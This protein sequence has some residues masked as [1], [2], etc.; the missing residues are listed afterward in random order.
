[1][2]SSW[3]RHYVRPLAMLVPSLLLTADQRPLALVASVSKYRL[4]S[5]EPITLNYLDGIAGPVE[6]ISG[7]RFQN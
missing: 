5:C 3:L 6:A 7:R 4:V 1:M 2:V